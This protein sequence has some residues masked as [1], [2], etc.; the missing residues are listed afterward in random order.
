MFFLR[1]LFTSLLHFLSWRTGSQ[2]IFYFTEAEKKKASEIRFP[3]AF[4]ISIEKRYL[5]TK[6]TVLPVQVHS[7]THAYTTA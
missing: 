4:V 3:E 5:T 6:Q 1:E 7:H 2:K